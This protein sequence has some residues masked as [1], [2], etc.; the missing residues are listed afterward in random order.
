MNLELLD[1]GNT[2]PSSGIKITQ[3]YRDVVLLF[4]HDV[5]YN[6][7]SFH[8]NLM[9]NFLVLLLRYRLDLIVWFTSII[10]VSQVIDN[11]LVEK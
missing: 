3:V 1:K 11:M 6:S 10:G 7:F 2:I 9:K 4:L 5:Q 8:E